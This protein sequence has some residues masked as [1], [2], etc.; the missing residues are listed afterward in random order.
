MSNGSQGNKS[1][2]VCGSSMP[3]MPWG[4]DSC[5]WD[6][7]HVQL[8]KDRAKTCE[9][10][11]TEVSQLANELSAER[12][13]RLAAEDIV[14]RSLAHFPEKKLRALAHGY[15]TQYPRVGEDI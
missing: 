5:E 12:T 7:K 3:H 9:E 8:A 1:C 15:R 10:L 6:P 4:T 13:R 2:S 11:V 14:D